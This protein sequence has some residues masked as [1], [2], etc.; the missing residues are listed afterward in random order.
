[1]EDSIIRIPKNLEWYRPLVNAI[2]MFESTSS[3]NYVYLTAKHLYVT[4]ENLGN[5][6]GWHSEGFGSN[7][8]NYIW[9]DSYPT[10]FCVQPFDLSD[11]HELS[12]IQMSV[13]ANITNIKTYGEKT[14]LRLDPSVIHRVP[15]NASSGYRTFVKISCSDSKYNLKGNAHNYLFDY[16]WEM[17]ERDDSRNH[18]SK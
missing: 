1:M 10:E 12:M 9:S 16:D 13:Q 2:P 7:D 14:L 15:E 18:L 5:R 6:P 11:H 4:P 8:I 17:F 3:W